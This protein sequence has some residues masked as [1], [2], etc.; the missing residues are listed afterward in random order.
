MIELVQ[1]D[2]NQTKGR[3]I[4][5]VGIYFKIKYF[6]NQNGQSIKNFTE[7]QLISFQFPNEIL[8][9]LVKICLK[10]GLK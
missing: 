8:E 3:C 1:F 5:M 2:F 10:Y 9:L 4:T 6:L 7:L